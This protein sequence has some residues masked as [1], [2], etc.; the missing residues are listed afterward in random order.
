MPIIRVEMFEGRTTEQ[1]RRFAEAA[2]A[3]F[4]EACGGTAQSVQIIFSDVARADWATGGKL[5]IEAKA[6]A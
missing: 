2:T 1:K 6:Q 5:N 4:V 3:A